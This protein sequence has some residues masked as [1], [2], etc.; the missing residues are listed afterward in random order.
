ME[1][2]VVVANVPVTSGQE[3]LAKRLFDVT[4]QEISNP[5]LLVVVASGASIFAENL[6]L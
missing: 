2:G 1:A 6:Q 3:P 4:V 5:I